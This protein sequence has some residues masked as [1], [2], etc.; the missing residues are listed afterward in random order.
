LFALLEKD[1]SSLH[2]YFEHYAALPEI[3]AEK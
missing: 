3:A 2:S 1:I